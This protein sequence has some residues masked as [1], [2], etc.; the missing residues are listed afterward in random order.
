MSFQI[1]IITNFITYLFWNIWPR[2]ALDL[3][4]SC[5]SFLSA[6]LTGVYYHCCVFRLLSQNTLPHGVC[7][8]QHFVVHSLKSWDAQ[9]QDV[10]KFRVLG[11]SCSAFYLWCGITVSSGRRSKWAPLTSFIR[12]LILCPFIKSPW[13]PSSLLKFPLLTP[14]PWG[15]DVTC[16]FGG[17]T[18][19]LLK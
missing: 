2:W 19:S 13:I 8:Q 10:W 14:T 16:K 7:K 1:C 9:G 11:G 17:N 4:S 6:D 3:S 15:K 18:F 12:A 5:L